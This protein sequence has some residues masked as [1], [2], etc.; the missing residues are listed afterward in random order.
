MKCIAEQLS[1]VPI[2]SEFFL[3]AFSYRVG[4]VTIEGEDGLADL[5]VDGVV[6]RL[7][8][9]AARG[10]LIER[11]VELPEVLDLDDNVKFM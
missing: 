10:D 2:P 8:R 1:F 6:Q 9:A 3:T 11:A 5:A 4:E 7:G